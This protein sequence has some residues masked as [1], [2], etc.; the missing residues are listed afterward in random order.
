MRFKNHE[1]AQAHLARL[2]KLVGA[3]R[4]AAL[5]AAE[6]KKGMRYVFEKPA[7]PLR[8]R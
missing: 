5:I 4:A 8:R 7:S 2:R 1:I 3:Q 6:E